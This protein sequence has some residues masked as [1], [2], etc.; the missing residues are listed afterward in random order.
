M[1]F[2]TETSLLPWLLSGAA[3]LYAINV[4]RGWG[5]LP[6]WRVG[7]ALALTLSALLFYFDHFLTYWELDETS[8]RQRKLWKRK[9]IAWRDVTRVGRLGFAGKD[10]MI[11]Y[12]RASEDRAYSLV[13]PCNRERF[14]EALRRFATQAEFEV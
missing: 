7:F 1:R 13:N 4:I 9:E 11:S 12:G 14:I 8:L 3:C 5:L 2:R 6:L 10:V